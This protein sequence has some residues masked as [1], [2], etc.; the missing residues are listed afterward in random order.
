MTHL[1][2]TRELLDAILD[3]RRN[4]GDLVPVVMAHL[5]DLCPACNE[6]FQE[7]QDS[8]VDTPPQNLDEAL[9]RVRERSQQLISGVEHEVQASRKRVFDLLALPQQDRLETISSAGSEY[10]G[11]A[12]ASLLIDQC[13][14]SLPA[15]PKRSLACAELAK[16]VLE[17]SDFGLLAVE[18]Y[19]RAVAYTANAWRI[20][21]KLGEAA[22]AMQDA[23]FLLKSNGGG[24]RLV[25]AELDNLEGLLRVYQRQ[26]P[27]AI[28]LLR[29][30]VFGYRGAGLEHEALRSSLNLALAYRH[31]G[32]IEEAVKLLKGIEQS[33]EGAD[34][35]LLSF[36]RHNLAYALCEAGEYHDARARLEL[37]R[38]D[39]F[40]KDPVSLLRGLWVEGRISTGLEEYDKAE[41][42]LREAA[43]GFAAEELPYEHA[44]VNLDLALVYLQQQKIGQV[45]QLAQELVAS[46]RDWGIQ[47]EAVAAAMLFEESV[48]LGQITL[49]L[50]EQLTRYFEQAERN[51]S[52]P[53][54]FGS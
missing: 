27:E 26:M 41:Q 25:K 4:P 51:P 3:G 9:A 46:F 22:T 15:Y 10:R 31:A 33:L 36:A 6:A 47:R 7:W 52:V 34:S 20:Q 43:Y 23:R 28:R 16:A 18:L 50:I 54:D 12:L 24:D 53:F 42:Q 5:F 29:R 45:H 21:A 8:L 32:E 14:E 30:A 2:L 39:E 44:L 35:P 49:A 11:L 17:H 37:L 13:R 19:A 48:R 38:A 1:H 40:L